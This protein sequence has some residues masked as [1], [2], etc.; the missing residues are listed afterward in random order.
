V[1]IIRL[2][3]LCFSLAAGFRQ[4]LPRWAM[5]GTAAAERPI[6]VL[7]DPVDQEAVVACQA[8]FSSKLVAGPIMLSKQGTEAVLSQG[9][10]GGGALNQEYAF[11]TAWLRGP[12][13]SFHWSANGRA[14]L[15][16]REIIAGVTCPKGQEGDR[17]TGGFSLA[18]SHTPPVPADQAPSAAVPAPPVHSAPNA[19]GFTMLFLPQMLSP[20]TTDEQAVRQQNGHVLVKIQHGD[21]IRAVLA[22]DG[23]LDVLCQDFIHKR[24]RHVSGWQTSLGSAPVY[25]GLGLRHTT[26]VTL[27]RGR[28]DV[29]EGESPHRS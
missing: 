8:H 29:E 4:P 28:R 13:Q 15:A 10:V 26:I 9:F 3:G 18:L 5:A 7:P 17:L 14:S 2:C 25:A 21:A 27:M 16:W 11:G 20:W 22:E 1:Q 12:L 19:W 24:W 6:P 23:W